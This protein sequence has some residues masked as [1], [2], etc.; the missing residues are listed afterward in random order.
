LLL[1]TELAQPGTTIL[2]GVQLKM[3]EGWHT[4]GKIPVP[5]AWPRRLNGIC[6]PVSPPAKSNGR[7]RK[8]SP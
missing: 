7:C 3:D 5:P 8:S 2:A 6:R 4:T 1:P